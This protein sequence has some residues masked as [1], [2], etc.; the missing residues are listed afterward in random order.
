[1]ERE[2]F[3]HYL[4]LIKLSD[5]MSHFLGSNTVTKEILPIRTR[6][7]TDINLWRWCL[8]CFKKKKKSSK[9]TGRKKAPDI[10]RET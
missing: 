1:M 6:K 10:L 8:F 7:N 2:T 4:K 3:E 9:K 5:V